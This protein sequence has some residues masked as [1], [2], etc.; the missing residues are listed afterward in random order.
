V[1][2]V[3]LNGRVA[4]ERELS[5]VERGRKCELERDLAVLGGL[6]ADP[7]PAEPERQSRHVTD[8]EVDFATTRRRP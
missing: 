8:I 3:L 5:A 2:D 1:G 6:R 7:R 4:E